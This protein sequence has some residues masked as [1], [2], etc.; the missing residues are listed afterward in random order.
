[1]A[2]GQVSVGVNSGFAHCVEK[3]GFVFF[4]IFLF[5]AF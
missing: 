3:M 2:A 4:F 1:M 5:V